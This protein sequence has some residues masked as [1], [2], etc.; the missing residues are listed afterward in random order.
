MKNEKLKPNQ[1]LPCSRCE[2]PKKFKKGT[3]S[4]FAK[5]EENGDYS[6]D[7]KFFCSKECFGLECNDRGAQMYKIN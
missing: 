4:C 2:T 1:V 3:F 5:K 7:Y 6:A